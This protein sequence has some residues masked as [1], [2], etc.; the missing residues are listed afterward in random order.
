M[1]NSGHAAEAGPAPG[2]SGAEREGRRPGC[3]PARGWLLAGGQLGPQPSGGSGDGAEPAAR[4]R[5]PST[6]PQLFLGPDL[7]H[8]T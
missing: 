5:L 1:F 4:T 6:S 2:L 3:F 7:R 8:A